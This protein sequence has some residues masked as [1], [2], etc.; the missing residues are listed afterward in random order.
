MLRT[1]SARF[2][3]PLVPTAS[4]VLRVP[5][6]SQSLR[7]GYPWGVGKNKP[8]NPNCPVAG[9]RTK[10]PHADDPIVKGLIHNFSDP[11]KV[12]HWTLIAIAEL[13][14]SMAADLHAGRTFALLSRHRQQEE[15]Y[16]RAL[17]VLF[18]ATPEELAH[19]VSDMTPNSFSAMYRAVNELVFGG[20]GLLDVQ[21]SGKSHG[22]FTAMNPINS[23]A[24]ASFSTMMMVVGLVQNPAY[25]EPY[26]SGRY[27]SH[28]SVY[29]L[30]P[31]LSQGDV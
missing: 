16:I 3:S 14:K 5:I 30:L 6:M 7:P 11:T 13:G 4:P 15:L 9:C 10:A 23:G 2:A 1:G 21:Q 25:L 26:T 27:F 12:A 20:R 24:H 28:I 22:T 8:P 19:I 18:I 17:Y 31:Q 29:C